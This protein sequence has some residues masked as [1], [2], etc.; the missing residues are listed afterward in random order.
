MKTEQKIACH[1]WDITI[2]RTQCTAD[3]LK[4]WLKKNTKKWGFQAEIGATTGY[5]HWQ[6]RFSLITKVRLGKRECKAQLHL[7]QRPSRIKLLQLRFER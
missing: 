5:E 1:V 4:I 2:A 7:E 6:G 3:E